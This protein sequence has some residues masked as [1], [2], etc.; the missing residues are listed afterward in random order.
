MEKKSHPFGVPFAHYGATITREAQSENISIFGHS[1]RNG[2]YFAPVKQYKDVEFYKKHP[3]ISF[4][5]I[6]NLGNYKVIG[7]FM[8]D[9]S[10]GN[11]KMF[12]YHDAVD[13]DEVG[14]NDYIDNVMKRSY[15]TTDVD[16]E[17]GD[18]LITLSTC[19]YEVNNTDFRVALVARKVRP[20]ENT[21]VNTS[22]AQKNANQLMPDRW[23]TKKGIKNPFSN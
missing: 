14:F 7:L 22:I 18:K 11:T 4:D 23:Y 12:A 13:L 6:Y 19:D 15:F 17:Y 2:S 8:E 1:A 5:T 9:V 3:I 16:V 21:D 10:Q 20:G